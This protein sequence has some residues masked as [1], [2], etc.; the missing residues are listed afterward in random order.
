MLLLVQEQ[1]IETVRA[2]MD[3][4]WDGLVEREEN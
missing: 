3:E 2:L 1:D 4:R